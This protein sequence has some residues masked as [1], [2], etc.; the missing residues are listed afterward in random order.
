MKSTKKLSTVQ[1]RAVKVYFKVSDELHMQIYNDL[2]ELS[3]SMGVSLSTATGMALRGGVPLL[4]KDW[5]DLQTK[6]SSRK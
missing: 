1:Y 5:N 4:K 3:K 2:Q 6:Q